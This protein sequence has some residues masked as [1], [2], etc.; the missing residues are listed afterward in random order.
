MLTGQMTCAQNV[1]FAFQPC[2]S[3]SQ[4]G[5]PSLFPLRM[6][7]MDG[8]FVVQVLPS[9]FG[10]EPTGILFSCCGVRFVDVCVCLCWVS[11][12]SP[13]SDV[14]NGGCSFVMHLLPFPLPYAFISFANVLK[15]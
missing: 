4:T 3:M 7:K 5:V 14:S 8:C 13:L 15:E 11:V 6:S 9:P 12:A 2:V 1:S 10:D